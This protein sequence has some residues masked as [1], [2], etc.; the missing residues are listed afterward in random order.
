MLV[1]LT[2][3]GARLHEFNGLLQRGFRL[4]AL[5]GASIRDVLCTQFSVSSEYV[6]KRINTIF[7]KGKS[8]DDVDTA[9]IDDGA[10]LALSAAMPGFVGAA[11][12]KGGHYAVMRRE[13]SHV[14]GDS[15]GSTRNG[16][17]I[18]KLYNAVAD[19]LGPLFLG[20]GIEMN[21]AE[22]LQFLETRP[23]SFGAGCTE[24][25]VDGVSVPWDEVLSRLGSEAPDGLTHIT[26]NGAP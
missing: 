14:Q 2:W 11:F 5:V 18:L 8:V 19:D 24:A 26:V 20:H 17:F 6:D 16:T 10:V 12:R 7:L 13:I 1:K 4:A 3:D 25:R 21:T 22:L 9:V 15:S 23:P